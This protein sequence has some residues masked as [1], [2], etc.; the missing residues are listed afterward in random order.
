MERQG[1]GL[2][3]CFADLLLREGAALERGRGRDDLRL[4]GGPL[5]GDQ[6]GSLTTASGPLIRA[7]RA[8]DVEAIEAIVERS[9][10]GY[11]ESLGFRPGPMGEDYRDL[12]G[13]GL[14]SVLEDGGSVVGLLV[15]LEEPGHLQV[16][17]VA[18]VPE[19]QGEGIGRALLDHAEGRAREVGVAEIR[20]YTHSKMTENRAIYSHLGYRETDR[21]DADGF[22][23]VFLVKELGIQKH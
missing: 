6:A 15:L 4:L 10:G 23:R 12:V 13:R 2:R 11:V 22:D 17:N 9:Y 7:A 5:E 19:R 3:R 16:E 14:V 8:A 1:L 20:L 21:R 18:V